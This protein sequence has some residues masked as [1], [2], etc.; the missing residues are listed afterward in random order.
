MTILK[1]YLDNYKKY[2]KKYG[3]KTVILMQI[4]SFFEIYGYSKD[5]DYIGNVIE[6]CSLL[7]ISCVN[8]R[9]PENSL[10]GGFKTEIIDKYLNKLLENDY[11]AVIIEQDKNNPQK[12]FVS[13]IYSKGTYT[14]NITKN[15]NYIC[16]IYIEQFNSKQKIVNY[17]GLSIIDISTNQSYVY[18]CVDKHDDPQF[19]IDETNRFI[20]AFQPNEIII[21]ANEIKTNVVDKINATNYKYNVSFDKEFTKIH[22]QNSFLEKL[23]KINKPLVKFGLQHTPSAVISYMCLLQFIFEHNPKNIQNLDEPKIWENQKYLTLDTNCVQQLNLNELFELINFTNTNMGNRLMK[24]RLFNPIIDKNV[25]TQRYNK[26]ESINKTQMIY[27]KNKLK[28]MCDTEKIHNKILKQTVKPYEIYSLL[29]S[30]E[31]IC[32][33]I[34]YNH[35]NK[36]FKICHKNIKQYINKIKNIFIIDNLPSFDKSNEP[37]FVKGVFKDIDKMFEIRKINQTK[38]NNIMTYISNKID[39]KKNCVKLNYNN[40]DGY[41]ITTTNK[42]SNILKKKTN[43]YQYKKSSG[44]DP[45]I[46]ITNPE[47]KLICKTLTDIHDNINHVHTLKFLEIVSTKLKNKNV[48]KKVDKYISD[49]DVTISNC[50]LKFKHSYNKPTFNENNIYCKELRHPIVEKVQTNIQFIPNDVIIDEKNNGL[51][52][53]SLNG[54]GKT[55][56]MKSIGLAIILAQSGFYTPCQEMSF[57]PVHKIFTRI[58]GVDNL[59]KQQSSFDV[60]MTELDSILQRSDQNSLALMDEISKGTEHYSGVSIVASTI[61]TLS[62]KNVKFICTSHLYKLTEIT[63]IKILDN[64]SFKHMEV[65]FDN[66]NIV[67]KRILKNGPGPSIYGIEV[68]NHIIHNKD[69]IK[70]AY[71]I[72]NE[73]THEQ[74]T[75]LQTN[76]SKY[77]TEHY[78]DKCELCDEIKQLDVHH[79][80]FQCNA[81]DNDIIKHFNKNNKHNLVTLCKKHHVQVHSNKI[82][83]QGWI[84]KDNQRI[85]QYQNVVNVKKNKKFSEKDIQIVMTL[86][87][88]KQK[89]AVNVLKHKHGI[90]ISKSTLSK[91]RRKC[92]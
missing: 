53:M 62:K 2:T 1:Y 89:D 71:Q 45:K 66:G 16:S 30:Y 73:I 82:N 31:I 67:Y 8:K 36:Y 78:V 42:R 48:F 49:L 47:I 43:N 19:A 41:H 57:K 20:L 86:N 91:I 56:Y 79:I 28:N 32:N 84:V 33:I 75:I 39:K 61:H 37:V 22:Y 15:N 35:D 87:H 44:K 50:V 6:I 29:I 40:R 25:L 63:Q 5:N 69:F 72:R 60:E 11:T 76:K 59:F 7:N 23:F 52:I 4:G 58:L 18:E 34:Q 74:Q 3:K 64:L 46:T 65:E 55:I 21:N 88:L 13:N 80:D 77:N 10:M 83:I 54:S 38:L 92:Y 17:I 26:T 27:I 24:H 51:V 12:R 70:L 68:A 90:T 85:L 14:E 81:D 9:F